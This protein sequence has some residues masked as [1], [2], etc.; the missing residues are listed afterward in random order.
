LIRQFHRG[1][2]GKKRRS[3]IINPFR[4]ACGKAYSTLRYPVVRGPAPTGWLSGI[5]ACHFSN[6]PGPSASVGLV[7]SEDVTPYS[8]LLPVG[9]A[10]AAVVACHIGMEVLPRPVRSYC[11][12]DNRAARSVV[13]PC[14]PSNCLGPRARSCCY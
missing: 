4:V 11:D 12:R 2:T 3:R 6:K 13:P 14:L 10:T 5:A 9:D 7:V 1:R 8:L